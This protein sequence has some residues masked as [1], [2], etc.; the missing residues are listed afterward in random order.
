MVALLRAPLPLPDPDRG[1]SRT[2]YSS[3]RV[4][5]LLWDWGEH[6]RGEGAFAR[7]GNDVELL[8]V[9]VKTHH[10]QSRLPLR[11]E[12][13]DIGYAIAHHF[14]ADS[15]ERAVL[16]GW[17]VLGHGER[18]GQEYDALDPH[19][20][21]TTKIDELQGRDSVAAPEQVHAACFPNGWGRFRV[22]PEQVGQAQNR[23]VSRIRHEL[24]TGEPVPIVAPDV[25]EAARQAACLAALPT[26]PKHAEMVFAWAAGES[27]AQIGRDYHMT[28]PAVH[29]VVREYRQRVL[30]AC[31]TN[32]VK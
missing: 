23:A 6:E 9:Q 26:N 18:T 19:S 8:G 31:L 11:V 22:T 4:R 15:F 30:A 32:L 24:N 7:A 27:L 13:L 29:H 21:A 3:A 5:A 25:D 10:P 2:A 1:D 20:Y 16:H 12:I 17:Y 28:R 14:R